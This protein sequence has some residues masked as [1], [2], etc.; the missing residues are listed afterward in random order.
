MADGE[1]ALEELVTDLGSAAGRMRC[2]SCGG[3]RF[4]S[5]C[6]LGVSPFANALLGPGDLGRMEPFFPLH[7]MVCQ[8]CWL[9]Q[10]GE[11]QSPEEIFGDYAYFSSY[12]ESWVR[13]AEAYAEAMRARLR[14]DGSS[15]VVE[16]ASNDG[17]LLQAFV[18]AG[19]PVLGIEPAANVAEVARARGVRTDV[20]FFG[21]DLARRLAT[22]G[23]RPRLIVANNVL[24]HAPALN[25]FV[26]GIGI[27]LAEDGLA[28]F[29]F[30]HLERLIVGG[31]FDTIYHEHLC[32]FSLLAVA[33]VFAR[34][35]LEVFDVEELPTHGGSLRL[36]VRHAADGPPSARMTALRD[37]E[38]AGGLRELQTY[39]GFAERACEAKRGLLDFLIGEKRAG[40]RIV[41][42][43]AAAKGA[44]LLNYC[45]VGADF[46]DYVVDRNPHKQGRY[47]PGARIPIFPPERI[48]ETR[49]DDVLILPWNL[50]DEV[51]EQ[52]AYV[53]GW[54]GRFV[55]PI[56]EVQVIA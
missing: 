5:V 29:E 21:T 9:V 48:A 22:E 37:R 44:T 2:R 56:P 6:D 28:T 13:H 8:D 41:A 18:K 38:I 52:L 34:H 55:L 4:G 53:R 36:Y 32:Y 1:S 12:S 11:F 35:G 33:P 3:A 26:A 45:G 42:Y 17:Y 27:L 30:P 54:G 51:I 20:A 39:A 24:A 46:I 49:P 10:L 15:L 16:I 50:K 31:Q 25:D 47:L 23:L 43:G 40:R 14:L 7:A 19:V